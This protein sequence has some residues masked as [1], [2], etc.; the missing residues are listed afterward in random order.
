MTPIQHVLTANKRSMTGRKGQELCYP[1]MDMNEIVGIPYHF[2]LVKL[3]TT[4]NNLT[5]FLHH[6]IL[7]SH[8]PVPLTGF[9][10]NF[11]ETQFPMQLSPVKHE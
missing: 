2:P 8:R 5:C 4:K 7:L 10:R 6:G 11:G 9:L 1:G 3:K